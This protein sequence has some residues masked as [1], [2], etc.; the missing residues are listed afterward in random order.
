MA[1]E[2]GFVDSHRLDRNDALVRVKAFDP[3][4]EQHWITVR[5]RRHHPLDIK[6]TDGSAGRLIVHFKA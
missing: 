4:D 5:Q 2:E 3:V 1:L 6:R